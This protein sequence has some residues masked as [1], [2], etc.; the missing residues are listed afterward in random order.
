MVEPKAFVWTIGILIVLRNTFFAATVIPM[1]SKYPIKLVPNFIRCSNN[2]FSG[3][4]QKP[5][6]Q[7]LIFNWVRCVPAEI[8]KHL[9]Y[10]NRVMVG[11]V[12]FVLACTT[13]YTV[14][15]HLLPFRVF[16]KFRY[17]WV[18]MLMEYYTKHA[19]DLIYA[20]NNLQQQ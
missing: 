19:S 6:I 13:L 9:L 20:L 15:L 11:D 10:K 2:Y 18:W 14:I 16:A 5:F 12:L 1:Y 7:S 3:K 17:V 4:G 8:I